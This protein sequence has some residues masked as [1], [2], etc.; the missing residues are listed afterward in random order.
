MLIAII[1]GDSVLLGLF[2]LLDEFLGVH[3]FVE[4]RYD[5][6]FILYDIHEF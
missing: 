5:E 2:E 3:K 6:D 4:F 1:I